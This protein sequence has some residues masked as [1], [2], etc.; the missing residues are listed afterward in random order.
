MNQGC[1]VLGIV[2]VVGSAVTTILAPRRVV[3]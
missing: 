2:L 3:A 1:L